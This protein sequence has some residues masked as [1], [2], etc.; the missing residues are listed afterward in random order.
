M[1]KLFYVV[2][3][4][5][6]MF[7]TGCPQDEVKVKGAEQVHTDFYQQ[8]ILDNSIIK[9]QPTEEEKEQQLRE[10][11]E[12]EV[13]SLWKIYLEDNKASSKDGRWDVLDEFAH[14]LVKYVRKFQT[15]GIKRGKKIIRLPEHENTHLLLATMV[16]FETALYHEAV[17]PIGEVGLLQ[18]H[19]V[20]LN[21]FKPAHVQRN[22]DLGLMLGVRWLTL[23]VPHCDKSTDSKWCDDDWLGP[24]S[25]YVGGL[26]KAK[27][28]GR[29][30][31]FKVS[32]RRVEY[33]KYYRNRID[34][35]L[36]V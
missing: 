4:S 17:G 15:E 3:M 16:T 13:V 1:E 5:I 34:S 19:G 29:C 25:I 9:E 33:T 7:L 30:L 21:G 10:S 26:R 24:L 11:M 32:K 31:K 27:R 12:D 35:S 22:P 8:T 6:C 23:Q 28:N 18:T 20:A 2:L 36:S 14:S